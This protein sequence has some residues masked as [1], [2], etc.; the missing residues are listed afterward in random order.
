[1]LGDDEIY[2]FAF[3]MKAQIVACADDF[4]TTGESLASKAV[5]IKAV[6]HS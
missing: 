2:R 3:D 4:V 5:A 6:F 1:M